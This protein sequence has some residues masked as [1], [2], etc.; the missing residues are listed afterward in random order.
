MG[1]QGGEESPQTAP[2]AAGGGWSF[3]STGTTEQSPR[4]PVP[5]EGPKPARLQVVPPGVCRSPGALKGIALCSWALLATGC[6]QASSPVG[7]S[8]ALWGY[9][10]EKKGFRL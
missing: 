1:C 3:P 8:G 2:G 9:H 10:H 7:A 4:F 6:C 5:S